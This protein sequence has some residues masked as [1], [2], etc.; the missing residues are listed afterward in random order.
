MKTAEFQV[1]TGA[2]QYCPKEVPEDVTNKV[3]E[4]LKNQKDSVK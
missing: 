2:L 4:A 3:N 1:I